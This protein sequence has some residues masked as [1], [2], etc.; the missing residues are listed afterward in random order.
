MISAAGP[1]GRL[2]RDAGLLG[3]PPVERGD[4]VVL[5]QDPE[6]VDPKS[7]PQ[8]D[9]HEAERAGEG[10]PNLDAK[11]LLQRIRPQHAP[12]TSNG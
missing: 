5:Q 4:G 12:A 3:T 7:R 8:G 2:W 9:V 1:T 6:R 10:S 11:A